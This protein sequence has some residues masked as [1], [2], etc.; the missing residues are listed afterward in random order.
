MKEACLRSDVFLIYEE[1]ADSV[2]HEVWRLDLV[3]KIRGSTERIGLLDYDLPLQT[4]YEAGNIKMMSLLMAYEYD[5]QSD[6][7]LAEF[8]YCVSNAITTGKIREALTLCEQKGVP[9]VV[10][11]EHGNNMLAMDDDGKSDPYCRVQIFDQQHLTKYR[12]QTLNPI[13][14]EDLL[15]IIPF[16]FMDRLLHV[17]QFKDGVGAPVSN[18]NLHNKSGTDL[19]GGPGGGTNFNMDI[20]ALGASVADMGLRGQS[21]AAIDINQSVVTGLAMP[22]YAQKA[23]QKDLKETYHKDFEFRTAQNQGDI[24]K[25]MESDSL[26]LMRRA[27]TD[28]TKQS[29]G[30]I[31]SGPGGGGGG[32]NAP[33]IHY[34]NASGKLTVRFRV[35]DHDV[36]DEDDY[37]G[38]YKTKIIMNQDTSEFHQKKQT[39]KLQYL[40]G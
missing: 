4:A 6:E 36:D 11:M 18:A 20:T 10:R 31:L 9:M 21:F 23:I 8:E 17:E 2:A 38:A 34:G 39:S 24:E 27:T 5:K 25:A 28:P 33:K 40:Q 15:F 35:F 19:W 3:L 14:E 13:W 32:A 7:N 16:E 37:M 26:G 29:D 30:N 22:N 1:L 12:K